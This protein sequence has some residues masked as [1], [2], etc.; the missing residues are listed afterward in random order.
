MSTNGLIQSMWHR[1][2]WSEGFES[3][4][5]SSAGSLMLTTVAGR[6]KQL[7]CPGDWTGRRVRQ[8]EQP[9]GPGTGMH[10][11]RGMAYTCIRELVT[12]CMW[13]INIVG[14]HYDGDWPWVGQSARSPHM[15]HLGFS[16]ME[17]G[18]TLRF[19]SSV[20]LLNLSASAELWPHKLTDVHCG[21]RHIITLSLL[22][23]NF[24]GV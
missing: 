17:P 5:A 2:K 19:H 4:M 3:F 11:S 12:H 24:W 23:S 10:L 1:L 6:W 14:S 18:Q 16:T 22:S 21:G 7:D 15:M 8:R 20:L 9:Q 13:A